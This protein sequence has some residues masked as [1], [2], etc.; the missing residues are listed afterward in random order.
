MVKLPQAF[1]TLTKP[2]VWG[3]EVLLIL[4]TEYSCIRHSL[5]VYFWYFYWKCLLHKCWML[6]LTDLTWNTTQ[7]LYFPSELWESAG[8]SSLFPVTGSKQGS[9]FWSGGRPCVN[10][11]PHLAQP[12]QVT[13]AP[14]SQDFALGQHEGFCQ[15]H[16]EPFFGARIGVVTNRNEP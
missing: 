15:S 8:E 3:S 6:L 12:G 5:N 14:G 16:P 1:K 9:R 11:A 4:T 10:D 13:R 7:L 2:V